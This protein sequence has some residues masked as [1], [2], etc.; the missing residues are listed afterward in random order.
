MVHPADYLGIRGYL[1]GDRFGPGGVPGLDGAGIV[2]ALGPDVDPASGIGVGTR[3]ILFPA[4][5]TWTEEV[6][7]PVSTLIPIPDDIDDSV[8]CQLA[9]NGATAVMLLQGAEQALG[10]S[11]TL[12]MLFSA[13]GSSVA[14]NMIA[15]AQMRNRR[16]IGLARRS[17]DATALSSQY[18]NLQM[19]STDH[20]D[21]QAQVRSIAGG[22]LNVIVDPIGGAMM[23]EFL[24]LLE[25]GGTLITYGALDPKLSQISS[26]VIT[27]RE[28]VIRGLSAPRWIN[29]RSKAK[30]DA[31]FESLF[32]MARQ[33]PQNV[34]AYRN[35]PLEAGVEEIVSAEGAS[36]KG[37]LI[38][39][40]S[41]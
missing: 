8:A 25:D 1:P 13:A 31:A 20:E 14:R 23:A 9:T 40:T 6:V 4:K 32:E 22:P 15:L 34:D 12:P 2:E 28:L 37:A 38:L 3:V 21:W 35:V 27:G 7:V 10:G 33:S 17:A 19:V 39:Q 16:V 11:D 41:P 24:N 29:R 18:D 30:Q 5:G 36:R 26:G